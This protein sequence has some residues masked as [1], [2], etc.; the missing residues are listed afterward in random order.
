M[1]PAEQA[2]TQ[3]AVVTTPTDRE[4]HIVREFAAPRDRVFA[5]FTDPEL[6][7]EWWGPRGTT[8]TVDRGASAWWRPVAPMTCAA[9]IRVTRSPP[10]RCVSR[11]A[12]TSGAE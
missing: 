2:Q 6:I 9:Q 11:T 12:S 7:P 4:I 5:V 8:T 1:T 10:W 3:A